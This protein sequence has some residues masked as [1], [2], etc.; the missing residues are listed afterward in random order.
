MRTIKLGSSVIVGSVLALAT[1][2]ALALPAFPQAQGWGAESVGGRGGRIIQVTNLNDSGEGSLR[3]ALETD[4]PR[5]VVFRV[6]GIINLQD[7]IKVEDHPYVT[8]AGQT[9]PGGGITVRGARIRLDSDDV[10]MRFLSVRPGVAAPPDSDGLKFTNGAERVIVDHVSTSW[11]NDESIDIYCDSGACHDITFSSNLIAEGLQGHSCS[12]IA[13]S[14][15]GLAAT[16]TIH[17]DIIG[18]LM[19][20]AENRMP[21]LKIKNARL[22]NNLISHGQW[23]QTMLRGGLEVDVI[24]NVYRRPSAGGGSNSAYEI[25]AW[26]RDCVGVP[27]YGDEGTCGDPSIYITG[28][29][30]PHA[31]PDEDNWPMIEWGSPNS[32]QRP[33]A[34]CRRDEP[35]ADSPAP[36]QILPAAGL[37]DI[38]LA[39]VGNS[40]RLDEHGAWVPRRDAVDARLVQEYLTDTGTVPASEN[41][42]GGYPD[43]AAGEP[44]ADDDVDG[45]ADVWET[46]H[47]FDPTDAADGNGDCDGDG[48]TNVE[49]FLNGSG[50]CPGDDPATPPGT[51]GTGAGGSGGGAE[52]ASGGCGGSAG[53]GEDCGCEQ[54]AATDHE[55]GCALTGSGRST[56]GAFGWLLAALGALGVK[57]RRAS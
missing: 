28:N 11:S 36:I 10:I 9:A 14:N 54:L 38:V 13:G 56:R 8:I 35:Q 45:M 37:E 44:Y 1:S 47:G 12:M 32:N 50:P 20:H 5:I 15:N 27:T 25:M 7:T 19:I 2:S 3:A 6:A 42:V 33:P 29:S 46:E 55:C 43:I 53:A 39:D 51:G 49:E 41:D 52:P 26:G 30:G 4:G 17:I 48:Y 57:R 21:F 23:M 16:E 40:R 22:V 18:N 34:S 31:G 24:N